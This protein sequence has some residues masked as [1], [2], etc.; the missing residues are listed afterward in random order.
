MSGVRRFVIFLLVLAITATFIGPASARPRWKQKIDKMVS[1]RDVSVAVEDEGRTLY[2]WGAARSRIPAS[3]QKLLVSMALLEVLPPDQRITTTAGAH[4]TSL[5][6]VVEGDLWILGRGDP[7]ITGGGRFGRSLPFPAT[8]LRKLARNIKDAGV[9]HVRGSVKGSTTFFDRDWWASGWKSDFPRRYIALPSALSFEGNVRDGKHISNPEWRAAR[10]L[11]RKLRR[12]GV[13]VN[14]SPGA[15]RAPTGLA[16]VATVKSVPLG[17][18]L[19]YMNRK[20][21]NFFAEVLGKR[22]G[23]ERSGASGTIARGAAAVRDWASRR[24][25][26]VAAHDASGLSYSNRISPLGMVRLLGESEA[27]PSGVV[28]FG[29]L[30]SGGQGTLK[31]RLHG[32]PVR[33][34]TGTLNNISTLS[35]YVWLERT[36]SWAEFSIMSSGMYKSTASSLEDAIVRHLTRAAR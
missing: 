1:G 7:S 22:L 35:G 31:D 25:E 28:L 24:G 17:R 2:R 9:T 26:S 18:M 14:G 29:S 13:S 30:P 15:G 12:L 32:T 34:K 10:S 8:S 27:S 4:S 36:G 19:Q 5:T 11:T 23:R 33:A 6:G 21:S 20:S 16:P 3:N